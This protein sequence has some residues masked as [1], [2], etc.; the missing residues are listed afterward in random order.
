MMTIGSNTCKRI[1]FRVA[2]VHKPFLS[3]CGCADMGFHCYL[4]DKGGHL[5]DK[6]TGEKIPLERRDNLYITSAWIR[7]DLGISV[8]QA[9][10][11]PS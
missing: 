1:V 4:G 3:I 2:D 10:V 11:G 7:Q 9:F 6:Q 5:L 8:S